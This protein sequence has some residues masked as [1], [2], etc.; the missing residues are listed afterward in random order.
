[1]FYQVQRAFR[2]GTAQ[3]DV[4]EG[5]RA[6]MSIL[7]R[8]LQSMRPTHVD[9]AM[10]LLVVPSE[11]PVRPPD[12]LTTQRLPS[13]ATRDNYLRDLCFITRENDEWVA[14]AYR[15][16]NAASGVG[17][18]YRMEV[19]RTNNSRPDL[20]ALALSDLSWLVSTSRVDHTNFHQVV[21]GVVHFWVD[22]YTVDG[23]ISSN[24]LFQLPGQAATLSYGFT[25]RVLPA[26]VDLELA[27][28][29]PGAVEKFRARPTTAATEYLSRQIGRTHVFRQRVAIRAGTSAT[30]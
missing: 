11:F 28:L 20:S 14:T 15:V 6:A 17:T 25:N 27:V 5:G 10:N 3:V 22:A 1:M 7:T 26:Y 16:R 12:T 13:Q 29:E 2:A 9:G 30:E 4:M 18:L 24:G 19:R 8:E 21:D 23:W